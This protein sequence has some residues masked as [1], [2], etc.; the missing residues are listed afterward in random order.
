MKTKPTILIVDDEEI[1]LM[2]F[3]A[4]FE[5]KFSFL[6]AYSGKEALQKINQNSDIQMVFTDM[7]M[8]GMNG[9]EFI[10]EARKTLPNIPYFMFSGYDINQELRDAINSEIITKFHHKPINFFEVEKNIN[11]IM[12]L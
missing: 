3:E 5:E 11:Q 7:K 4:A 2:L 9:L 1:N 6:K 10:I 8:P 12:E